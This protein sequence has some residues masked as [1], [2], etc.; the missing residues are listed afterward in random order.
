MTEFSAVWTNRFQL[1]FCTLLSLLFISNV[2]AQDNAVVSK[3]PA[4]YLN[5]FRLQSQNQSEVIN[6][7]I[8][9]R[10]KWHPGSTVMLLEAMRFVRNA[11]NSKNVLLLAEQKTGQY[12]GDDFD[13]WYDWVWSQKYDPH[14]EY[15][16]FK[17]MLYSRI[18]A[19]FAEYFVDTKNAKIRLDEVRWGGVR[20]DGIP[21]LKNPVMLKPNQATYL[22]DSNKVFGISING[23]SRAYPNRILAWHEMFKDTIGGVSVCGVY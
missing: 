6:G 12:I 2:S 9:I 22:A 3:Q 8:N 18:D 19:R 11:N 17:K 7:Y 4:S 15:E 1:F 13:K 23:D 14:P 21:P 16:E 10:E 5:F 20:R